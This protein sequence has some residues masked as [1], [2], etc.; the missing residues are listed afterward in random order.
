MC[1]MQNYSDA[2]K[3]TDFIKVE[4]IAKTSYILRT[5]V[6]CEPLSNVNILFEI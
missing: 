4:G 1:V 5:D 6:E 3:K 2:G